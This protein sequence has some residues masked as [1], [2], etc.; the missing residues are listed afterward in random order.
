MSTSATS[1]QK[2]GQ[3]GGPRPNQTA[4]EA[5]LYQLMENIISLQQVAQEQ[6][7]QT[8]NLQQQVAGIVSTIQSTNAALLQHHGQNLTQN[9]Q[10]QQ[11]FERMATSLASIVSHQTTI[12]YKTSNM[13]HR[14]CFADPDFSSVIRAV[15]NFA[16]GESWGIT[17][18]CARL[19]KHAITSSRWTVGKCKNKCD[20]RRAKYDKILKYHAQREHPYAVDE[21]AWDEDQDSTGFIAFQHPDVQKVMA[22][23][24]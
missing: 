23:R 9:A 18:Q 1:Q 17:P 20:E 24:I 15:H 13:E 8:A 6:A 22:T 21:T 19:A 16:T 7:R 14:Q 4:P 3:K 10:Q 5:M 12:N 2:G 11:V